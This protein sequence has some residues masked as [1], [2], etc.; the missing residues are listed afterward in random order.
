MTRNGRKFASALYFSLA[1]LSHATGCASRALE[2]RAATRSVGRQHSLR[3]NGVVIRIFEEQD[4]D[5]AWNLIGNRRVALL[6]PKN[7][8]QGVWSRAH[9]GEHVWSPSVSTAPIRGLSISFED[10]TNFEQLRE[11]ADESPTLDDT[12]IVV[13]DGVGAAS[14]GG[15]VCIVYV[16][17]KGA[18][19]AYEVQGGANAVPDE[20]FLSAASARCC[21]SEGAR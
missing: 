21:A 6:V 15:K 13:V 11:L 16:R 14:R 7:W 12:P 10:E 18:T 19:I 3:R 9:H 4:G 20:V 17:I 2:C 5:F 1:L 8:G